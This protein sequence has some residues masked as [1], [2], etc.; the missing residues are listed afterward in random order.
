MSDIRLPDGTL[1]HD[2]DTITPPGSHSQRFGVGD[3]PEVMNPHKL[4]VAQPGAEE[5]TRVTAMALSSGDFSVKQGEKDRYGRDLIAIDPKEG[6]PALTSDMVALG[7]MRP[8]HWKTIDDKGASFAALTRPG[9]EMLTGGSASKFAQREDVKALAEDASNQRIAWLEQRIKSGAMGENTRYIAPPTDPR[10]TDKGKTTSAI[11]GAAW[12]RGIDNTQSMFYGFANALGGAT[13]ADVLANWGEDGVARNVVQAMRNPARVASYED[14]DGLADF[15]IYA[16]E[17]IVENSP[18]LLGDLGIGAL[19]GGTGVLAKQALAGAGK[20]LLRSAGG[21]LA[22]S[23]ARQIAADGLLRSSTKFGFMDSAKAGAMASMYA[24]VTGETQNQLVS[25]GID[26][27]GLALAVGVPKAALDYVGL[28]SVLSQGLKGLGKSAL[29]PTTAGELLASTAKATGIAATTESLTEATQTLMDELAV[30][31]NK[32]DYQINTRNI[33]DALFKGGLAG[34]AH[35]GASHAAVGTVQ[36]GMQNSQVRPDAAPVTETRAEP[37]K[38]VQAQIQQIPEGQLRHF[39]AQN[40]DAAMQAAQDAGK[41][42]RVIDGGH[43][44]VANTQAELDAAPMSPTEA[45]NQRLLGFAQTKEQALAD[46]AG[47]VV[48]QAH[49]PEGAVVGEQLVGKSMAAQVAERYKQQFP[50]ASV[51]ETTPEQVIARRDEQVKAERPATEQKPAQPPRDISQELTQAAELGIDLKHYVKTGLGEAVLDR[52]K[53]GLKADLPGNKQR[54]LDSLAPLAQLL[55]VAPEELTRGYYDSRNV[56]RGRDLLHDRFNELLTDKFGSPAEF[57]KAVDQLPALEAEKIQR[58][59]DLKQEGGIA[60]GALREAIKTRSS[61]PTALPSPAVDIDSV[62]AAAQPKAQPDV[63]R[64]AVFNTPLL[65]QLLVNRDGVVGDRD[66]IESAIDQQPNGER[67]LLEQT[68]KNMDIDVGGKNRESFLALLRD[69]VA[70]KAAYGIGKSRVDDTQAEGD[71]ETVGT[72]E[73]DPSALDSEDARLVQLVAS[74]PLTDKAMNGWPSGVSLYMEALAKIVKAGEDEKGSVL[75]ETESQSLG[76]ARKLG[77]LL[78]AAV[79]KDPRMELGP[80][81]TAAAKYAGVSDELMSKAAGQPLDVAR[82]MQQMVKN[83]DGR[84]ASG[85]LTVLSR[86]NDLGATDQENLQATMQALASNPDA[87]LR[88]LVDSLTRLNGTRA[89][90]DLSMVTLYED[91]NPG[92]RQLTATTKGHDA[93]RGDSVAIN[94]TSMLNE[95]EGSDRTFFGRMAAVSVRNW[96]LAVLPTTEQLKAVEFGNALAKTITQRFKGRNLLAL[97]MFDGTQFGRV[98]DAVSLANFA[99]GGERA[100]SNPAEAVANLLENI[101]RLMAGA[102]NSHD[103]LADTPRA[104]VRRIP[105]DLVIFVDPVTAEAVTFGDALSHQRAGQNARARQAKVQKRLD[106]MA[107]EIDTLADSLA[108]TAADFEAHAADSMHL[109][110]VREAIDL[111][112]Q[113]LAGEKETTAEGRKVYFRKPD[114]KVNPALRAAVDQLGRLKA[115]KQTLDEAFNQYKALLGERS[116]LAKESAQLSADGAKREAPTDEQIVAGK[117]SI[118]GEVSNAPVTYDGAANAGDRRAIE[119]T[120]RGGQRTAGIQQDPDSVDTL[121]RSNASLDDV[122][123]EFNAYA[124]GPLSRFGDE[125]IGD[126]E[127]QMQDARLE[128]LIAQARAPATM[129]STKSPT[130]RPKVLAAKQGNDKVFDSRFRDLVNQLRKAGVPLPELR[131]MVLGRGATAESEITRLGLDAVAAQRVRDN[132]LAGDSFYFSHNGVAHIVIAERQGPMARA[133]QLADLAHELGHAV[134]DVVWSDLQSEHRDELR[135]AIKADLG[136]DA[137][138]H[139]EHEWFADQFAKA[140][141]ENS[142]TLVKEDTGMI[143]QVLRALLNNLKKVWATVIGTSPETNPAFRNFAKSLF[144]GQYAEVRS[145]GFGLESAIR[146][147]AHS[148]PR[149]VVR[150]ASGA[151]DV[152]GAAAQAQLLKSRANA[153]WK[154]GVLPRAA[155]LFSMVYSRIARYNE[156]LSRALFQPANAQQSVLGQSWEQRSRAIKG[157]MMSQ[158]DRLLS[159]LHSGTPGNRV[160]RDLAVQAAF[161]DA[162]SGKPTTES[163]K[164]I[165]KVVDALV[166]EATRSGLRSV[167]LG[168]NFAPIAFD[169]KVIGDRL[170]EF[171]KLLADKLKLEPTETRQM[172]DRILHGPGVLEGVIAPGMPVGVHQTTRELANAVGLEQLMND[173][174]LLKKH[175]AVLFHWVDGVGKRAAWEAIFGGAV[176]GEFESVGGKVRAKYSPNSKFHALLDDVRKEHGEPAAQEVM[177]LVNGALGRHPAGQSMPSWWRNTQEFITGWVGMTVLAFSGVASIPELALPLVRAGGKV[178]IGDAISDYRQAKQLA[179][180]MGIVLSDAS[181]QVMWQMTGEQY[182]SSTISKMQSWFFWLNGNEAIVKTSRTLATSIGVRYL[183]NAAA[184]ADNASLKQLNVDAGS[185]LAWDA[186]GRPAWSPALSPEMQATAG[187]VGDALN[188]FVNEATLNPSKFQATHWGNN[189][190][191]KMAWHLKHFLYTYGDTVLGGMYREMRRRWQHLDPKQFGQAVAIAMPAIIFGLAVMPLAAGSLELRD[192]M[193]RLNGRPGSEYEDS[194]DYM[195]ATFSRAGGLGPLEFLTTL[196]QQQEWGMSIWGSISPVAGKVDSLF[197]KQTA[198]EKMRGLIPVWSQNKTMFGALK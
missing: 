135:A 160:E 106:K 53:G 168:E 104:V 151:Q 125:A 184:N 187:A 102:Q 5:A 175:D 163:G 54:R 12:D 29:T 178:G 138:E 3:A 193:R 88:G 34:G 129:A 90:D 113:M 157:R 114:R 84:A 120:L 38:D 130:E 37:L 169:R 85:L 69:S 97:P 116:R 154:K 42:A 23:K 60:L 15:G 87:A 137:N 188:Q 52:A 56:I 70:E 139:L 66:H 126:L 57:A 198:A 107:D 105:D 144:A 50:G 45:D 165:R 22:V 101:T 170:P 143:N 166:A 140:V 93:G 72:V 149:E 40:A 195:Q 128:A 162:Y 83:T 13:G 124:D 183:L 110:S 31:S 11:I 86:Q 152:R 67:V 43:V 148:A 16:L 21:P 99:Q 155:P 192:W 185:V 94:E 186:A 109:L 95:Q 197:S 177:A 59:F 41:V 36:M 131:V 79:K 190:Y 62:P 182:Q 133:H 89:L 123:P 78:K 161:E 118:G 68:L 27:P 119:N 111:W 115:G 191:L 167:D 46:P 108:E 98:I 63:V 121:G 176:A 77:G 141:M 1:V 174:W 173:G 172:V 61:T 196:R 33:I 82:G 80:L 30:K 19:T 74:T 194:L 112:R 122:D 159:E 96:T 164:K 48:V 8:G 9:A 49:T 158:V 44:Q 103:P 25:E 24:Q 91:Q 136:V 55:D 28:H 4:T 32:P 100:P 20:A 153:F 51:I 75:S 7:L 134:K 81:M 47:T 6:G 39:T 76:M 2:A 10:E 181:E 189:P 35:A 145:P 64:D 142:E 65:R 132:I 73:F 92:E 127:D 179:K 147:A 18:Q 14:I 17:A 26:N 180:D 58:A 156:T 117:L 150:F 146:E 171:H 71:S